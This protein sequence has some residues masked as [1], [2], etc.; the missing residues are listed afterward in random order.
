MSPNELE[1]R[2]G[3]WIVKE[4]ELKEMGRGDATALKSE[5]KGMRRG[6]KL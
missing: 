3:K 4:S 1:I 6:D 5:L 2:A